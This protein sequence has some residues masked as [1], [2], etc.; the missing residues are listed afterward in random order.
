MVWTP[1]DPAIFFTLN[2][3][4]STVNKAHLVRVKMICC[5]DCSILIYK[6]NIH[7]NFLQE[8][9]QPRIGSGIF[10]VYDKCLNVSITYITRMKRQGTSSFISWGKRWLVNATYFWGPLNCLIYK[11]ISFIISKNYPRKNPFW[12]INPINLFAQ[13]SLA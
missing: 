12:F 3:K 2:G 6:D 7:N 10:I 1:P 13:P 9:I 8:S 4:K 11:I 5:S